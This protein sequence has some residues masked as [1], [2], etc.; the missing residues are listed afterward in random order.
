VFCGFAA[1]LS[2]YAPQPLLPL[3]QREFGASPGVVSLL[4]TAPMLAVGLAAP[5]AGMLADRYGRRQI[6]VPSAF[7]IAVPAIAAATAQS[8]GQLLFWRFWQGVFTPGIFA[9]VIAYINEEWERGAGKAVSGY[10]SGTVIGG[11]TGRMLSALLAS[12]FSWRWAFFVLGLLNVAAAL[13]IRA[14]LPPGRRFIPRPHSRLPLREMRRHLRDPLLLAIFTV[15]YCVLFSLG[16]TFTY[17]NFYLA[18]PPFRLGTA[19]LGLLFAVYLVGAVVTPISGRWIDRVGHKTSLVIAL[20]TGA[21]GVLLTLVENLAVVLIGL[22]MCCSGVFMAQAATSSY[23]G[24][25]AKE[26]RAAAVGLYVMFYYFGGSSG[27]A[28]P[29]LLWNRWGWTGC[30]ALIAGLDLFAIAMALAFWRTVG[31]AGKPALAPVEEA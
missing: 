21:A 11:F 20:S 14:K 4:I 5:F 2:I 19:W 12:E 25:A 8:L 28:L 9:V 27:S 24:T 13:V 16:G 23:I 29:G 10:V 3:L 6:I 22:S 18:A 30:V 17:V 7:L 31:T 15:G 26:A 1:F